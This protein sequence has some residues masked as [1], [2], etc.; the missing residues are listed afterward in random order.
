MRTNYSILKEHKPKSAVQSM[1]NGPITLLTYLTKV[2]K[3]VDKNWTQLKINI[4]VTTPKQIL[5][6]ESTL[7]NT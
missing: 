5:K 1:K 4:R 7:K 6:L 2:L 3:K